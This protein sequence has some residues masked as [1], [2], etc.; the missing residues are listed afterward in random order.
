MPIHGRTHRPASSRARK[1][2][3]LAEALAALPDDTREVLTLFYREGQSIAQVAEL[4]DLTDAAVRKRLSRARQ[5]LRA[6]VLERVGETLKTSAPGA[7]FTAGILAALSA[8][9][10]ATAAASTLIASKTLVKAG[11][12]AKFLPAALAALPGAAGGVTGVLLGS[13]SFVRAARDEEELR[14][15]RRYRLVA[16]VVV[17]LFALGMPIEVLVTGWRYWAA[18]DFVAFVL[19]L[20]W[21]QHVW[22]HRVISRRLEAEMR[23]DPVRA[24]KQR[25]R[26]RRGAIIGWS[27]GLTFG[28]L[29]LVAGL[30]FSN[31]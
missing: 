17:V 25:Q 15:V 1:R 30:W 11:L 19:A 24:T 7:A 12:G 31:H 28:T 20:A 2:A 18:V 16:S 13:R 9:A 4:L 5:S 8:S 21:L 27:L 14:G 10:P 29:G 22:L 26:E 6:A 3:A 23:E